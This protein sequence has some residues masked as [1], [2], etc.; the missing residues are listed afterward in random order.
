MQ[1]RR[2]EE[3][4]KRREQ[5][6]RTQE[7]KSLYISNMFGVDFN[8]DFLKKASI[9]YKNLRLDMFKDET[10]KALQEKSFKGLYLRLQF[11]INQI[12]KSLHLDNRKAL[13]KLHNNN[14]MVMKSIILFLSYLRDVVLDLRVQGISDIESYEWQKQ[15][16]LTWNASEPG[17]KV[18][19]GGWSS[20]QGN[21]YLGSRYR[22]PITP[23]TNRYFVFRSAALR[24]K[25][26]VI[27]ECVSDQSHTKDIY[28]EYSNICT[29]CMQTFQCK[30]SVQTLG[31]QLKSLLKYLKG[32]AS[33]N[34]W[35][36]YEHLDKLTYSEFKAFTKEI[37]MMQRQFIT[38]E[39]TNALK[40]LHMI[41]Q[42]LM[43]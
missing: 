33:V 32:A 17:C 18:E 29:V 41:N 25:S 37:Q 9:D 5:E 30:D 6:L 38:Q 14:H 31:S 4:A 10:M 34:A 20:Y 7:E 23:L 2:Q 19:C 42:V 39:L 28:E 26:A 3:E 24:E 43:K 27:L 15:M 8:I 35:V 36:H 1:T 21:E 13:F 16:R 11:W 40:D 12:Y 22:L